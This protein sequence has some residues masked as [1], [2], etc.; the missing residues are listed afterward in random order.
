[1]YSIPALDFGILIASAFTF[2]NSLLPW[3]G[4]IAGLGIGFTLA[5]GLIAW[6]GGMLTKVFSGG[7]R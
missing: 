1:M 3:L 5:M 7:R 4:P 2:A 6:L